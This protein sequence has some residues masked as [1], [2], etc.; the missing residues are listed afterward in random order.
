VS[1]FGGSTILNLYAIWSSGYIIKFNKGDIRSVVG[2]MPSIV[3]YS[4]N[5]ILAPCGYSLDPVRYTVH[6]M[7]YFTSPGDWDNP[8]AESS[9]EEVELYQF[10]GWTA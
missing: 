9:G 8:P 5:I 3:T 2:T 6:R 10:D 4:D 7:K 1:D